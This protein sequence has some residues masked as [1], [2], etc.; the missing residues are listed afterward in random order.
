MEGVKDIPVLYV[1]RKSLAKAYEKA[2]L[3]LYKKGVRVK[4]EMHIFFKTHDGIYSLQL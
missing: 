4:D 3:L 2:L 1:R